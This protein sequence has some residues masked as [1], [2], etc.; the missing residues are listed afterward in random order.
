[1]AKEEPVSAED[2]LEE[3]KFRI[4]LLEDLVK[5][6]QHLIDPCHPISCFSWQEQAKILVGERR[7]RT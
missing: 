4:F 6:A 5:Q 7:D 1:M 2:D 3:L